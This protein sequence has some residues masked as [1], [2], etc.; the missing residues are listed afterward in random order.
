MR[1]GNEGVM[2]DPGQRRADD[3][4]RGNG[5]RRKGQLATY[6]PT[7]PHVR[8]SGLTSGSFAR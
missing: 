8:P 3:K 1:N 5:K 2:A 6:H 7:L 4:S